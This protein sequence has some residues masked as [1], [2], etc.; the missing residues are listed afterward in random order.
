[1]TVA[2]SLVVAA[3]FCVLTSSVALAQSP[4]VTQWKV[5]VVESCKKEINRSCK[6]VAAGDGRLLACLHAREKSL[7]AGCKTAVSAA[8]DRLRRAYAARSEAQ[9]ICERDARQYCAG[10]VAGGGNLVDC[11]VKARARVSRACIAILD[12]ALLRP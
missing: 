3:W 11:L 9:R 7:S 12:E 10:T 5:Y 1:M 8:L 4:E 6:S 2:K